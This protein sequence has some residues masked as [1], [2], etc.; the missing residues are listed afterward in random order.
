ME[1]EQGIMVDLTLLKLTGIGV[2]PYSARGITQ[3]LQPIDQATQNRRTING[4]L[5]DISLAAFQKYRS[6]I[7]ANDQL[8]PVCDGVWPGK[9]VEVECVQE[10]CYLTS[11]GTPQRTAVTGSER[12][13][14][15]F[16]YYRPKLQMKVSTWNASTDEWQAKCNWQ[17]DLEEI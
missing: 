5:K 7:S 15:D 11:G 10:L 13:E 2:A 17:M 12:V 6:T 8:A 16:T 3:T 9:T 14:G 1:R 4:V